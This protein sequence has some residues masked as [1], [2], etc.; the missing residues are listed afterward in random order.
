MA[1]V[2]DVARTAGVSVSTV[3]RVLNNSVLVTGEK[4]ERVLQAIEEVGYEVSRSKAARNSKNKAILVVS[5]I[6]VDDLFAGIEKAAF[7]HGYL[8]IQ[9]YIGVSRD[10]YAR[11]QELLQTL[12]DIICG[13]LLVNVVSKEENLP[14]LFSPFPVV[15][16]GEHYDLTPTYV[17][18]TDDEKAFYDMVMLLI[19]Q[20]KKQ[21]AFIGTGQGGVHEL[22]LNTERKHGY[23]RAL[24][25]SGLSY[26]PS[27]T[28]LAD[29]S[30]EGGQDAVQYLLGLKQPPDAI[31]CVADV[32]AV[33]CVK[34]L[35]KRNI[36]IPRQIAVTGFD[37]LPVAEACIPSITTVAQSFGEIGM[38]AVHTLDQVI[39]GQMTKGRKIFVSHEIIERETT[40]AAQN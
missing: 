26:D 28:Y 10:A 32:I 31:C 17:V 23:K 18:L 33:G 13:I 16:I 36:E 2:Q 7:E 27:Y 30:I 22:H 11:C 39:Q 12:Q 20:G 1:T 21:I 37:N 34:E 15:Q 35:S 25:G 8:V 19:K 38:E 24:Q 29:Y 6:L 9:E 40:A 14:L 4:R 5:S 3:S